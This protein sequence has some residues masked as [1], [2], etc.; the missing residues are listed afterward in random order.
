MKI[1]SIF[2]RN[3]NSLAGDNLIDF[4]RAPLSDAALFAITGP[5]GAGKSS[6]L[7]AIC[8][9]LYDKSPRMNQANKNYLLKTGALITKGKSECKVQ[10][11]YLHQ[12]HRYRSEWEIKTN[13]NGNLN[14]R[15]MALD[16]WKPELNAFQNIQSGHQAVP[17][18]NAEITGL[19]YH[20]FTRSILLAQG[21]FARLLAAKKEERYALMEKITGNNR[22]RQ[23]G[24]RIFQTAR[25]KSQEIEDLELELKGIKLLTEEELEALA[26]RQ[27][28]LK[29]ESSKFDHELMLLSAT[30]NTLSSYLKKQKELLDLQP[31]QASWTE[32]KQA[33]EPQQKRLYQ[34]R[35]LIPLASDLQ[36]WQRNQ[37][38]QYELNSSIE[39]LIQQ[40]K[41]LKQAIE[42]QKKKWE[43]KLGK[44]FSKDGFQAELDKELQQVAHIQEQWKAWESKLQLVQQ[45]LES[46]QKVFEELRAKEKQAEESLS[47]EKNRQELNVKAIQ[48]LMP[49]RERIQQ[50]ERLFERAKG[51][52][53][54]PEDFN[55]QFPGWNKEGYLDL[56]K[57]KLYS[58]LGLI[59]NKLE[60]LNKIG[61]SVELQNQLK[62]ANEENNLLQKLADSLSLFETRTLEHTSYR[63][64]QKQVQEQLVNSQKQEAALALE[65]K[66]LDEEKK[67][68]SLRQ[69]VLDAEAQLS[70]LRNQL[71]AGDVC[72]LCG[73]TEHPGNL[74]T[75]DELSELIQAFEQKQADFE[76][77]RE[78]SLRKLSSLTTQLEQ[79][80]KRIDQLDEELQTLEGSILK[81]LSPLSLQ[82][83]PN[84]ETL[85]SI[86]TKTKER[87][88]LL[89]ANL[90]KLIDQP[91]LQ[92]KENELEQLQKSFE[93]WQ[94]T[95][96]D[97]AKQLEL[98]PEQLSLEALREPMKQ[99][100]L[101]YDNWE[102]LHA[103]KKEIDMVLAALEAD[104]NNYKQQVNRAQDD[105]QNQQTQ[106]VALREESIPFKEAFES[107][108]AIE[109]PQEL[110][111]QEARFLEKLKA[112]LR[113]NNLALKEKQEKFDALKEAIRQ[114]EE[115]LFPTLQALHFE[116]PLA[117]LSCLL[118]H[119]QS[120]ELEKQEKLLEHEARDLAQNRERLEQEIVQLKTELP[121][122]QNLELLQEKLNQTREQL[123]LLNREIGEL[124]AQRK[125]D[126]EA[127]KG[128]A[129]KLTKIESLKHKAK[130]YLKLK[131]LIGDSEGKRF[132]EYAQELTLRRLLLS[133]NSNLNQL[134]PRYELD[135]HIEGEQ[136]ESLYI[137]DHEMGGSRRAAN[138]TLS[139][140]ESFLVSLSLALGLSDLAA[141]RAELGNLFIDEGFGS[142]D[143]DSLEKAIAMLEELQHKRG[144]I[145]GLISHVS[146]LKERILTQIRVTKKAG[147]LSEIE[148]SNQS[149]V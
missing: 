100:K 73:A 144:R 96:L 45:E 41:A 30:L 47:K 79:I 8:L 68:I 131:D 127:R 15:S 135:M 52:K 36:A 102:K 85:K 62:A 23:I 149:T 38:E 82:E 99:L 58:E 18:K 110:R 24:I 13:R 122:E 148:V 51:L 1:R 61:N 106:V 35:Q 49:I 64:N 67:L 117:A 56:F 32:K 114:L 84:I 53:K 31:L 20:Q 98:D 119:E 65:R 69:Q 92:I 137:I 71:K 91:T 103:E 120:L 48:D 130:P 140:G 9:A 10:V 37:T 143:P 107:A 123:N 109:N 129:E 104:F 147:G 139:G 142:L 75:P 12:G 136:D 81:Q 44:S 6:I 125:A 121:E 11:E 118:S 87:I 66:Q 138:I 5:T 34:H 4:S 93:T 128:L 86:Q 145:I 39:N 72:P 60:D 116:H 126:E 111:I 16:E 14:E 108:P 3:L 134:N 112:D 17:D 132:N 94:E 2:I 43:T 50:K 89:E 78:E 74:H 113:S 97:I 83:K 25:A 33:F 46:K 42:E 55:I 105:L 21:E 70:V 124:D 22:Y 115:Q 133:A 95:L 90:H 77:A 59:R 19:D 28:Q 57:T 88:E 26:N 80:Q 54:F 146:E 76:K 29:N 63:E 27:T 40:G 141:G 101:D 7:D